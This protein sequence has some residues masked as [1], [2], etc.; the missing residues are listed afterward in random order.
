MAERDA[1]TSAVQTTRYQAI[2]HGYPYQLVL[3]TSSTSYQIVSKPAGAA[4]F[5]N[6]GSAVPFTGLQ[7]VA[8]GQAVT[9]QFNPNGSVQAT[10][11]SLIMSMEGLLFQKAT[12]S[13]VN[14]SIGTC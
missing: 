5:S 11:G 9:L 7:G 2:M 1:V 13:G 6:V 12:K 3:T 8:L 14:V 4:S 10:T